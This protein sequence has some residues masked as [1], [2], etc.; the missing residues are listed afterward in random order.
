MTPDLALGGSGDLV[1]QVTNYLTRLNLLS[2]ESTLFDSHVEAAIKEFQQSRGLT[3]TGV[4]DAVTLRALDEARW[5][6]GDRVLSLTTPAMRGDDIAS[7]QSQLSEMGFNCGRVDGIY[8]SGTERAVMEFQKSVGA[9]VDGTCGPAT[10]MSML[11]LKK[12]VSGG[13]PLQLRDAIVRAE[14]GPALSGKVIV[15]DPS[16]APEIFDL[17]GRLEGRLIALGVNVFLTRTL[18][19]NPTDIER[20]EI[21][22]A[23]S[24]DLVISLHQDS[25]PN[26]KAHGIATYYY[27]SDSHGIHSIVGERFANLVQREIC[28]RTDLLN[29][30]T[31]AKTWDLLRLTKSPAVRIEL[32]Y[33]TNPGDVKRVNDPLFRETI[34]ESLMVAIQRLYLSAE[35]DAKTG[36]LKI[37]DL[38]KAGVRK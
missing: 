25:Y 13:A 22:N 28:A 5:K 20:V 12:I 11:R 35:N 18:A 14:K 30:R 4:V 7:L 2:Q 32:G 17:A 37:S 16:D 19:S 38:R 33:Q 9:K 6:L 26:E 8:G 24:A 3:V 21:A 15:I 27:G 1:L 36:T 31:H 23:A 34:V 10:I 29:C